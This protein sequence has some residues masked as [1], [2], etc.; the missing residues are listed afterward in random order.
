ME[1]R[2]LQTGNLVRKIRGEN[3]MQAVAFR[4]GGKEFAVCGFPST[5][6]IYNTW[7][8]Q[9][10]RTLRAHDTSN[11]A[12]RFSPDGSLL[13]VAGRAGMIRVWNAETWEV[14]HEFSWDGRPV[15]AL[16]FNST[17][18][19]LAVGGD[20][21]NIIL[22]NMKNNKR[23]VLQER[24]G[25]TFSLEFCG[26]NLL[27]SGESDNVIRFWNLA[28]KT[29]FAHTAGPEGHRGTIAVL[30]YDPTKNLLIS[31]SFDATVRSWPIPKLL[32]LERGHLTHLGNKT[33]PPM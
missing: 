26:E 15:N 13:A 18:T 8:G 4:H 16:A 30:V 3:G 22:W 2:N 24:P 21:P 25:K 19:Q 6:S 32:E 10:V 17:G 20:G 33:E 7:T 11:R 27:V 1:L 12:I 28:S 29:Y 31:G 5:V 14:V 23:S 9:L